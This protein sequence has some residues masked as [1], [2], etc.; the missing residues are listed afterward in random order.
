MVDWVEGVFQRGVMFLFR[1]L[2]TRQVL[3]AEH[4]RPILSE[5]SPSSTMGSLPSSDKQRM[6]EEFHNILTTLRQVD[7][8]HRDASS[9]FLRDR[10]KE[11]AIEPPPISYTISTV[12]RKL[13]Y[14]LATKTDELKHLSASVMTSEILGSGSSSRSTNSLSTDQVVPLEDAGG[15]GGGGRKSGF[16]VVFEDPFLLPEHSFSGPI[17]SHASF[18]FGDRSS[19]HENKTVPTTTRHYLDKPTVK[20]ATSRLPYILSC[21]TYL[22]D[23]LS[24]L[25]SLFSICLRDISS[26]RRQFHL[27]MVER[28]E[29][30]EQHLR[31]TFREV[32][33]TQAILIDTHR[34]KYSHEK[35]VLRFQ[36]HKL[37]TEVNLY[38]SRMVQYTNAIQSLLDQFAHQSL[39]IWDF[40][41]SCSGGTHNKNRHRH[42][43]G[44]VNYPFSGQTS[45]FEPNIIIPMTM[46]FDQLNLSH[47]GP[48]LHDTRMLFPIVSLTDNHNT[49]SSRTSTSSSSSSSSSSFPWLEISDRLTTWRP[50]TAATT[51]TGV[52]SVGV[53]YN[54]EMHRP[55]IFDEIK[56][57]IQDVID[58]LNEQNKLLIR[59]KQIHI[60]GQ[61]QDGKHEVGATGEGSIVTLS[62]LR[63]LDNIICDW[64]NVALPVMSILSWTRLY[65]VHLANQHANAGQHLR[66]H[67][68]KIETQLDMLRARIAQVHRDGLITLVSRRASGGT[69]VSSDDDVSAETSSPPSTDLHLAL[70]R[71]VASGGSSSSSSGSERK[72]ISLL[73]M[74][75][76]YEINKTKT[77]TL[78]NLE[79]Q[80]QIVQMAKP[81]ASSLDECI[82]WETQ[83]NELTRLLEICYTRPPP[84]ELFQGFVHTA[85]AIQRESDNTTKKYEEQIYITRQHVQS[86]L[87]EKC[88]DQCSKFRETIGHRRAERIDLEHKKFNIFDS[89]WQREV[90]ELRELENHIRMFHLEASLDRTVG[91]DVHQTGVLMNG[92]IDA[93]LQ[94][95]DLVRCRFE[96][97]DTRTLLGR[98]WA[99][100]HSIDHV[101]DSFLE[102]VILKE[103]EKDLA[104]WERERM[105]KLMASSRRSERVRDYVEK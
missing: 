39:H 94:Q 22:S 53:G 30:D 25:F 68:N 93:Y 78:S 71:G 97:A 19:D 20:P 87:M 32:A 67:Q 1:Q 31:Q 104:R 59:W 50:D 98:A 74:S 34:E 92:L 48:V 12:L 103:K 47:I 102:P 33:Q 65:I 5:S 27:E 11:F 26:V 62:S 57:R 100:M 63:D 46:E 70:L 56:R 105:I 75:I 96:L 35:D 4:R 21:A 51:T 45:L 10:A 60:L 72:S 86:M 95:I 44:F 58:S 8:T 83:A 16:P 64:R 91:S 61:Q 73:P 52:V 6:V 77:G 9:R 38:H 24:Q 13:G 54:D 28:A 88:N 101:H 43:H 66:F 99:I 42:S 49:L 80:K 79:L 14:N 89:R 18:P 76:L 36:K 17:P 23:R 41:Q 40:F 69:H 81:H 90:V 2:T 55:M 84:L 3:D 85:Q 15:S 7:Q 29:K 82:R 37:T